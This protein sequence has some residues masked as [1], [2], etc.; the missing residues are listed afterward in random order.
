MVTTKNSHLS[1]NRGQG[2]NR[3]LQLDAVCPNGGAKRGYARREHPVELLHIKYLGQQVAQ[4][5]I[6]TILNRYSREWGEGILRQE[7]ERALK[8]RRGR[9]VEAL[10]R[11]PSLQTLE[12]LVPVDEL[13]SLGLR[14]RKCQELALDYLCGVNNMLVTIFFFN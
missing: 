5:L 9:Q 14:T 12:E 3:D 4:V 6:C 10:F 1:L 13:V 7:D 11:F 8:P 2:H